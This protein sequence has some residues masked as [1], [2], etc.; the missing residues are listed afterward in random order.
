MPRTKSYDRDTAIDDAM[1]IFWENGYSAIGVRRIEKETS[2]NRF[3]LQTEFGGKQGLFREVLNRYLK[4]SAETTLK[5]LQCGGL[6]AL[7]EF[8]R[9]MATRRDSDP[10]DS[11]CL[12]V[13]TVIDNAALGSKDVR[14]ITAAHFESIRTMIESSLATARDD[15]EIEPD[16]DIQAAAQALLTFA[17][18]IQVCVR[19]DRDVSAARRQ[20]D[21]LIAQIEGWR[22]GRPG[23]SAV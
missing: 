16:F 9:A 7:T 2:I 20:V 14:Q 13:N 18:G 19:M 8:L 1:R 4:V 22:I 12:M 10:R 21:F 5:P 23:G 15:G 6:H 17:I 3:A 11:G